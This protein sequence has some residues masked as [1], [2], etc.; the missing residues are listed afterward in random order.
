[1]NDIHGTINGPEVF[2]HVRIILG[3]VLGLSVSRLIT[4]MT[5]FIQHPGRERIYLPHFTWALFLVLF[6]IHFWWFEFALAHRQDWSFNIYIF[7][8]FYAFLFVAM[9]AVIFPD[10]MD[11]YLGFE[12]YFKKRRRGFYILLL[13][14]LTVDVVDTL[15][16]GGDYYYH[17]YGWYY[18][19]RQAI[20]IA[21]TLAALAWRSDRYHAIFAVFAIIFE[22][23]WIVSLFE[24]IG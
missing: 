2:T 19:I 16:K 11:E 23:I 15:I 7:L 12:D 22:V 18:P 4:G 8:I 9:S 14:L 17:R 5:R 13:M 21:G 3:M 24:T 10:K 6:I 20:L 1:M